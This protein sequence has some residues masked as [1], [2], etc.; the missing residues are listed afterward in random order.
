MAR[1]SPRRSAFTLIELLVV[2]AI[3]AILIGL[4]LPA[5]QK[6]REAA[7]RMQSSNNLKQLALATHNASDTR[8]CFPLIHDVHWADFTRGPWVVGKSWNG[9]IGHG[10]FY[11]FLLPYI[12]Q[13]NLA[14][15]TL[16]QFEQANLKFTTEVKTLVS[17]LDPGPKAISSTEQYFHNGPSNFTG[18]TNCTSYAIN[19]QVF[20]GRGCMFPSGNA[21]TGSGW[22]PTWDNSRSPGRLLDGSSNTVLFAEKM[23]V[24][25]NAN[26]SNLEVGNAVFFCPECPIGSPAGTARTGWG[27]G[28][29]PLFNHVNV[30]LNPTTRLL[31]FPKFQTGV[32][33]QNANPN[34]AHALTAAGI[35]V[36]LGDGSVRMVGSSVSNGTWIAVCDPEDGLVTPSDW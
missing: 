13:S 17:P 3:I 4:L 16:N 2:I 7:A 31:E 10:S 36:A 1:S 20:G 18:V 30:T 8:G 14:G 28:S 19:Y 34:L 27:N 12:E 5:V 26:T 22:P 11:W 24:V 25:K 35:Q 15:P 23:M 29:Y 32:N 21:L 33:L 9:Q 6:V